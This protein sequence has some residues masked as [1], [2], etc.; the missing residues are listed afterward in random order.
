M[1]KAPFGRVDSGTE[2]KRDERDAAANGTSIPAV[3]QAYG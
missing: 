1:P 3:G 2:M